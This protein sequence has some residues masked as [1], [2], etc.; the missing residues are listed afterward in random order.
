MKLSQVLGSERKSDDGAGTIGGVAVGLG[1]DA[2]LWAAAHPVNKTNV[3]ATLLN[4]FIA[5]ALMARARSETKYISS[6]P[7]RT[8]QAGRAQRICVRMEGQPG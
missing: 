2:G 7:D 6:E 4:I 3:R 5:L 8:V 1:R